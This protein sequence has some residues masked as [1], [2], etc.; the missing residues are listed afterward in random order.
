MPNEIQAS[1][2]RK[3]DVE[4]MRGR[5]AAIESR[6]ADLNTSGQRLLARVRPTS[7]YSGQGGSRQEGALFPVCVG[8]A[9]QYY[10]AGGPGGQYRLQ[11]VDL[12]AVFEDSAPPVQITFE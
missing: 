5:F 8:P 7:K 1:P 11:D 2:L 3:I 10:V 6:Q 4:E 12:F 9:G